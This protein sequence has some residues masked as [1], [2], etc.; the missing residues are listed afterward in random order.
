MSS[1]RAPLRQTGG[2]GVV[3]PLVKEKPGLLP[4]HQVGQIGGT[5]HRHGDRPRDLTGQ[6]PGLLG[7]PLQPARPARAVLDHRRNPGHLAARPPPDRPDAPRPRRRWAG[8]RPH[9]RT[10]RSPR[11][12]SRP[13]RHGPAGKTACRKAAPARPAPGAIRSANH[14]WSIT[15]AGSRSSIRAMILDFTLTVTSPSGRRSPSSSTAR[16]PG[17]RPCVRRSVTSSSA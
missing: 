4:A 5:V 15:A 14:A 9:R 16:A 11:P 6:N 1:T 3:R 2:K 12:A 17:A 10:G 13:P 7:Q 8:P